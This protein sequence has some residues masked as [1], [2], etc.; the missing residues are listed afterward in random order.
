MDTGNALEN[1]SD[2]QPA[3]LLEALLGES[4]QLQVTSLQ[5]IR[6]SKELRTALILL[7][8]L[9]RNQHQQLMNQRD[10]FLQRSSQNS[11]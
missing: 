4:K 9:I 11:L 3:L 1:K 7:L 2:I 5:L 8:H 6:E 10:L